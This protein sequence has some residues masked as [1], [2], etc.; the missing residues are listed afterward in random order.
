M[1]I[2][3]CKCDYQDPVIFGHEIVLVVTKITKN[4]WRKY[5]PR[6]GGMD[7]G[8]QDFFSFFLSDNKKFTNP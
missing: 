4:V 6:S 5:I 8:T 3:V 1:Y 2:Q 7:F